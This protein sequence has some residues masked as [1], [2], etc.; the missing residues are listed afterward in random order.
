MTN[1]L[2]AKITNIRPEVRQ[3]AK[4]IKKNKNIN[5]FEIGYK[6]ISYNETTCLISYEEQIYLESILSKIELKET[7][8]KNRI[9]LENLIN[10][11]K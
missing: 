10:K 2:L 3:L 1:K 11:L 7:K 5:C 8:I 6:V 9:E 4:L